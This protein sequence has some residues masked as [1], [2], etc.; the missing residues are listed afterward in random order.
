MKT[1]T[2]LELITSISIFSTN[3]NK[4]IERELRYAIGTELEKDP[5]YLELKKLCDDAEGL[6]VDA[7]IEL[8]DNVCSY[9]DSKKNNIISTKVTIKRLSSVSHTPTLFFGTDKIIVELCSDEEVMVTGT[10]A[11]F[12]TIEHCLWLHSYDLSGKKIIIE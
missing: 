8:F 6:D 3:A 2:P 7:H 5:H 4:N 11:D 9:M 10:I 12:I 1:L